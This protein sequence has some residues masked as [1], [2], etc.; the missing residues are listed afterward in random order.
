MFYVIVL[1]VIKIVLDQVV[2]DQ[3]VLIFVVN[4]LDFVFK[5]LKSDIDFIKFGCN[6]QCSLNIVCD[7][8]DM[9]VLVVLIDFLV[10]CSVCYICMN[11]YY[12]LVV[13]ELIGIYYIVRKFNYKLIL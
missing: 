5:I 7:V 8:L 2:M 10:V 6:G 3:I 12:D 9:L 4:V 1:L 11:V 13:F